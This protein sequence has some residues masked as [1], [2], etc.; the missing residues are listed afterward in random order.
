VPDG[1]E[2]H[3]VV[4]VKTDFDD[5]PAADPAARAVQIGGRRQCGRGQRR[6]RGS[7]YRTGAILAVMKQQLLGIGQVK[8]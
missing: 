1:V 5:L 2:Q 6:I 7:T 3:L 8:I 4:L